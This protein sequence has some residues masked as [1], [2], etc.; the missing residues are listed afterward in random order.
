MWR[1]FVSVITALLLVLVIGCSNKDEGERLPGPTQPPVETQASHATNAPVES[2][3]EIARSLVP[4]GWALVDWYGS[5]DGAYLAVQTSGP[6]RPLGIADARTSFAVYRLGSSGPVEVARFVAC[7]L[8]QSFVSVPE[9]AKALDLDADGT[10]NIQA[11]FSMRRVEFVDRGLVRVEPS[12]DVVVSWLDDA[13]RAE[14]LPTRPA[15][16]GRIHDPWAVV[17]VTPVRP[18]VP[19]KPDP[20]KTYV[21]REGDTLPAIAARLGVPVNDLILINPEVEDSYFL[22]LGQEPA[23]PDRLQRME[24]VPAGVLPVGWDFSDA[25]WSPDRRY[26]A[27]TTVSAVQTGIGAPSQLSVYEV[28]ASTVREV[29]RDANM[30]IQIDHDRAFTDI[31]GDGQLDIV[32]S[33]TNGG[34]AWTGKASLAAT[35]KPGG[36][37]VDVPFLLPTSQSSPKEPLDADGNGIL[38]WL[39]IDA[40]WE[41]RY[42]THAESPASYFV[43][44]WDGQAYVDASDAFP[45]AVLSKRPDPSPP[46]SSAGC[47]EVM[48]YLSEAVGKVLDY[49]KVG[50]PAEAEWIMEDVRTL[51]L[52]GDIAAFRDE[53]IAALDGTSQPATSFMQACS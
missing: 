34:N 12:G 8:T 17:G 26:L 20:E 21:V 43:L 5:D 41:L 16:R 27:V 42:F 3:Q 24:E 51:Q 14:P 31:N 30:F 36:G 33:T 49:R 53:V 48:D 19:P 25:V 32:Y 23:V 6:D 29:W 2:M 10:R 37:A 28:S 38:E 18:N 22:H 11:A 46:V 44:A 50:R 4:A 9:S 47:W 13:R 35:L 1:Q 52:T 15:A 7:C 39:A 40:S 45:D